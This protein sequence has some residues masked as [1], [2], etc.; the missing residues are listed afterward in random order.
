MRGDE[1][2][3][4]H[5]FYRSKIL[6]VY[7]LLPYF[8]FSIIFIFPNIYL[9]DSRANVLCSYKDKAFLFNRKFGNF[10]VI[11]EFIENL[12]KMTKPLAK[13]KYDLCENNQI[14][15]FEMDVK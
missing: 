10:G 13:R 4:L 2:N 12:E 14:K 6:F 1:V 8:Y 7:W 3:I 15:K 9:I 5:G 11:V